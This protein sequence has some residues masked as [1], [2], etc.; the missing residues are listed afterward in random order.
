[1]TTTLRHLVTIAS[2]ARP[3]V[4]VRAS[5]L[6]AVLAAAFVSVGCDGTTGSTLVTFNA[7]AAGPDSAV[8]GEPFTF[9][10]SEGYTVTL[11]DARLLIG[12]VYLNRNEPS[13]NFINSPCY[14]SGLFTG[15]V[16]DSLIVNLLD[17][18]PQPF[19]SSGD[20][21]E[22]P[23]RSAEIWLFDGD[24]INRIADNTTVFSAEGTAEKDATLFPFTARLTI[25]SN[26]AV[27]PANPALPGSNPVCKERIVAPIAIDFTPTEGGTL[28]IRIDPA[29]IFRAV[30]FAALPSD[31]NDPPRYEFADAPE[32]PA[33]VALFDA[34]RTT[35]GVY[36]VAFTPA[37][38]QTQ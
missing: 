30:D 19:P 12:A 31:G 20:G 1:M 16:L 14:S 34:L 25:G 9:E 33:D 38:D 32:N 24:D 28:L 29:A 27:A 4:C 7:A 15:Q 23:S 11:D 35:S 17:P 22:D 6:A 8:A 18:T 26:R 37:P 36:S 10:N 5:A 13:I 2:H 21:T 3:R